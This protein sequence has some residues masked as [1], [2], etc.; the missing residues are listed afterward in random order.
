MYM[1]K[2]L[3]Q[4]FMKTALTAVLD[5]QQCDPQHWLG[6]MLYSHPAYCMTLIIMKGTVIGEYIFY[7]SQESETLYYR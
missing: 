1:Q 3:L 2:E 6:H 5:T 7:W 4:E